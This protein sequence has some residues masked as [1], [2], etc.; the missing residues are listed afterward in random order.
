M[1]AL[2]NN[3][4]LMITNINGYSC[5]LDTV[6]NNKQHSP[7]QN[8]YHAR[9]ATILEKYN[10]SYP[11]YSIYTLFKIPAT[12]C[13]MYH[14]FIFNLFKYLYRARCNKLT[15]ILAMEHTSLNQKH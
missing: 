5:I 12:P 9:K 1:I 4:K 10:I 15:S 6:K 8:S 13:S 14:F 3:S 2:K 11:A 7:I